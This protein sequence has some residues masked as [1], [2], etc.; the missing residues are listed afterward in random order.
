[1]STDPFSEIQSDSDRERQIDEQSDLAKE[2]AIVTRDRDGLM[3]INARHRAD[4]EQVRANYRHVSNAYDELT[5]Q[6]ARERELREGI[7][8]VLALTEEDTKRLTFLQEKSAGVDFYLKDGPSAESPM[9][10]F[11]QVRGMPI[12][13]ARSDLRAA[14]D[15]AIEAPE[16]L[17]F[18]PEELSIEEH[19]RKIG[20]PRQRQRPTS[21]NSTPPACA[22][23]RSSSAP[24]GATSTATAK[25]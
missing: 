11:W 21:T 4:L 7:E 12:N 19:R 18:T 13:K 9:R 24:R 8:R 2:L 16:T 22:S 3:E 10:E 20:D 15:A 17:D 14:I 25:A 23:G 1:M 5:Q 6:L